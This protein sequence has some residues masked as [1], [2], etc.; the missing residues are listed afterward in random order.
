M[1]MNDKYAKVIYSYGILE[2]R[3]GSV[4][5]LNDGFEIDTADDKSGFFFDYG[6]STFENVEFMWNLIPSS[7]SRDSLICAKYVDKLIIKNCKFK[8]NLN[9]K[10]SLIYAYKPYEP[11][12]GEIVEIDG[13]KWSKNHLDALLTIEGCEFVSNGTLWG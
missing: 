13:V 4:T 8:Y 12:I 1:K 2:W 3:G 10:Y 7:N 11:G 9:G 6:S 5:Y